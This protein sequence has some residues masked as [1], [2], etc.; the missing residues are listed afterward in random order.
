MLTK[1]AGLQPTG[2]RFMFGAVVESLFAQRWWV[3]VENDGKARRK[4]RQ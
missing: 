3:V 1:S 4:E 2:W